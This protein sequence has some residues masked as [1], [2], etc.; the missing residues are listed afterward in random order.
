MKLMKDK[1]DLI[2]GDFLVTVTTS[3]QVV[4]NLSSLF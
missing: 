3:F 1:N 4:G 2:G